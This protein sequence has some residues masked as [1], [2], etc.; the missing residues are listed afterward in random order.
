MRPDVEEFFCGISFDAYR[1]LG[2]HPA[3]PGRGWLFTLWAPHARRV[4]LLGDWNGW[5]LY[6]AAELTFCED[7]LWRGR[8]PQAQL[9]QLYKYNIQGPDGSWQLRADPFAFAFEALPG[10][11]SRLAEPNYPFAA[12]LL[13]GAR[14]DAPVL[15]YELHAA[16]WHRHWDG[17]YYTGP[18]LAKSL[19][20]YLVEHHY[21]HVEFLPLAEYPFDGSWGYQGCGYFAPTQRIGGFAGFAALVDALHTAGIAVLMDFVPV[22]FAPDADRLAGFDGAPLFESGPRVSG[23][24]NCDLASPPVRRAPNWAM[25]ADAGHRALAAYSKALNAFCLA[26][27]ALYAPQ[28]FAWTA[29][30]AST[31]VLGFT[32][33]AGCETLLC[34][35]NTGTQAVQGFGLKPGWG[36]CALPLFAAGW[37]DNAPRPIAN[38]WLALD[39]APLSGG[40]WQIE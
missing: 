4:Q 14:R 2:S 11:A 10:T 1:L 33:Q 12:P 28:S 21:T 15:I 5:D 34:A 22:H 35:L 23:R 16:S 18:E 17:R 13:R 26:H 37:V 38:G 6:S 25:L 24:L 3:G 9:G 19:V 31:G 32:L 39:L 30:D 36:S 29:Q 27:P 7:G 20:P 8:V 40:I